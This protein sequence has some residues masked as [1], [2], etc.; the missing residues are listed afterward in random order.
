[1]PIANQL[2]QQA[3]RPKAH[4]PLHHPH[5]YFKT[6]SVISYQEEYISNILTSH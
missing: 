3:I 6:W 4:P 1:M 5:T 2:S